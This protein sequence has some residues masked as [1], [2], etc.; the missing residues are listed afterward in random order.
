M[1]NTQKRLICPQRKVP[2][3]SRQLTF[4]VGYTILPQRAHG[5]FIS[6]PPLRSPPKLKFRLFTPGWNVVKRSSEAPKRP[7]FCQRG[8]KLCEEAERQRAALLFLSQAHRPVWRLDAELGPI[9]QSESASQRQ[10]ERTQEAGLRSFQSQRHRY[11]SEARAEVPKFIFS[12][13]YIAL[14]CKNSRIEALY[15]V[16]CRFYEFEKLFSST[17]WILI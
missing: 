3:L 4:S 13:L 8:C 6:R 15:T 16:R 9:T 7:K 10:S 11:K 5:G 17:T 12:F 14:N 1:F 2:T